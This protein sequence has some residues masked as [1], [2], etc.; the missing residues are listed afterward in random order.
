MDKAETTDKSVD[1]TKADADKEE[2]SKDHYVY[3]DL[4]N[5]ILSKHRKYIVT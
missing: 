5:D 3:I 1:E 4:E 2:Y